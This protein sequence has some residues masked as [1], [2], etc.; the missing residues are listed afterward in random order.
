MSD[1][2]TESYDVVVIGAGP[3]GIAATV[4]AARASRRVCLIDDAPFAGGQ[5]W[6]N[7]GTAPKISSAHRWLADLAACGSAVV[8]LTQS[9]VVASLERRALLVETPDGAKQVR[10]ASCFF[11]PSW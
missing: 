9:R 8:R 6:R 10:E 11:E 7:T 1:D 5:I 3:G 4:T 2:G